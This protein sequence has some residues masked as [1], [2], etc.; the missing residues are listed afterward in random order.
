MQKIPDK[1]ALSGAWHRA[2]PGI[3]KPAPTGTGLI[4]TKIACIRRSR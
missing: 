3:K 4:Q 1:D 2:V